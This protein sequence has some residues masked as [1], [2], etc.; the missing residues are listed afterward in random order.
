M[1]EELRIELKEN[2]GYSKNYNKIKIILNNLENTKKVLFN[3]KEIE[4]KEN[5]FTV[6]L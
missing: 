2:I 6:E 1:E 5:Q 3:N 4:V